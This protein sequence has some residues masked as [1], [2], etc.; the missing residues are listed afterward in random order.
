MSNYDDIINLNRP[1]SKKH[2]PMSLINRAAQFAPFAALTGYDDIITETGRTVDERIQ[3]DEY[4]II[5]INNQLIY[6]MQNK[7]ICAKYTYFVNDKKKT[8]G[9]YIS[10]VGN[11]KKYDVDNHR[12]ILCDNTQINIDDIFDIKQEI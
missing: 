11:I 6:L 7:D 2:K 1:I 5:D 9:E 12:I 10:V 8:G 4:K 3:L